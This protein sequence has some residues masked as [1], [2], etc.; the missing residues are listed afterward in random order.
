[1]QRIFIRDEAHYRKV[2]HYIEW[3]PVKA[4]LVKTQE[5][6]SRLA[7]ARLPPAFRY[8]GVTQLTDC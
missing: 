7:L 5:W 1:M 6:I 8:A 3:N 2:T 4:G